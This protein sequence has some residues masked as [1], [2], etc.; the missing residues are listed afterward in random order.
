MNAAE[1]SMNRIKAA[2]IH[3]MLSATV[4]GTLFAIIFLIWYPG[5][6]FRIAGASH[7]LLVLV[8]VDLVLGPMLTLIVFKEDRRLLRIDLTVIALIQLTA[9]VYGAYTFYQERPYY[10]V[11]AVD[12]FNIV[13][14]EQ[15]DQSKIRYDELKQKPFADVLLVFAK[16]PED[17]EEFQKFLFSVLDGAP[18]LESRAEYWEP[19]AANIDKVIEKA[20]PIGEFEAKNETEQKRIDGAISKYQAEHPKLG[21]MPIGTLSEDIGMLMDLETGMPLAVL[22]VDPWKAKPAE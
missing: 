6:T 8:G 7:I 1:K 21:V 13:A 3:L 10:M 4:V 2:A 5:T 15:I 17:P 11:F 22:D 16:K 19:Y 20:Q 9:L 12:R 18:D 14:E